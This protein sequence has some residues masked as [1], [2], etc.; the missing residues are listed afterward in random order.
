MLSHRR[1]DGVGRLRVELAG[2]G[3]GDA[4]HGAGVFDDHALQPQA[5]AEGGD[6]TLPCPAQGAE[7]PLDAAHAEPTGHEDRVDAAQ[8]P[9]SAGLGLALVAGHP[10]DDDLGVV[11][12]TTRTQ[13][14]GHRQVG[15]G[16]VD[17]LADER[18]LDLVLGVV[19]ALEHLVPRSPVD[20]A[21][22]QAQAADDVGVQALTVQDLG[23]VV[24]RRCID[25]RGDRVLV[26]VTHERDLALDRLG[27]LPVGPQDEPVGLDAD[28]AQGRHGVLRRLGLQLATRGEVGHQRDVQEEAVV[29]ADL[30]AHL[31]RGLKER[32]ALDVTDG[33][34]DLG[35]DEVGRVLVAGRQRPHPGL[36]LVGDVRDDLDRVAEVFPA[37]LLGDD[38]AVDLARRH[39]GGALEVDVEEALVVPDVQVGLGPVVGDEDLPVL[40]RVHRPGIHVE[41]GV[42]FLH[43]HPQPPAPEQM[44]KA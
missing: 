25:G 34:A 9:L 31:T 43:R 33:A 26:D 14:L 27:D 29:P 37:P 28:L 35:D 36:D 13:R 1:N 21:E 24:D 41:V 15:V 44:P 22:A 30:L 5:D 4:Q 18:D 7:L 3:V 19:D 16:E 11:V 23:D 17:V 12:E 38:G 8:G 40:E 2:G 10:A 20:V 42:E 6:L 32:Q 39:V